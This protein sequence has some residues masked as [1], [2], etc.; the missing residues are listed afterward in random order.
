MGK[1]LDSKKCPFQAV[2]NKN[3]APESSVNSEHDHPGEDRKQLGVYGWTPHGQR[4]QL[5]WFRGLQYIDL[6]IIREFSD[7]SFSNLD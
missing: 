2:E 7:K 1:D 3:L 5:M 4:C 6:F